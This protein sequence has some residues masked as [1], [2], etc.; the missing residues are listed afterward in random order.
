[1]TETELI[2]QGFSIEL[3]KI[4]IAINE[5]KTAVYTKSKYDDL[6]EWVN[7]DL[8]AKLKGGCSPDTIKNK[9][10]LQ[11]CCGTNYKTIGG[12]KT[13]RKDDVIAWLDITDSDLKKYADRWGVSIPEN[14]QRRGA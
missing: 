5:M 14:Y 7:I 13:W 12:R 9:L 11:P 4:T 1:M 8:A 3:S 2:L 10:F 6:P